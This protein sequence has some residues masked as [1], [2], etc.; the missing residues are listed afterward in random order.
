MEKDQE[1]FTS[2]QLNKIVYTDLDGTITVRDT[3]TKFILRYGNFDTF[4]LSFPIFFLQLFLFS[5]GLIDRNNLKRK[6]IKIFL[7]GKSRELL[8]KLSRD[9]IPSVRVYPEVMQKI[10]EYRQ[11]GYKIIVVTA[12]PSLYVKYFVKYFG[13]DGYI[14]TELEERNGLLTGNVIGDNNNFHVKVE[15]IKSSE[16]FIEGQKIVAFG[17]SK[18]DYGMFDLSDEFFYVNKKGVLLH[19]TKP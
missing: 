11:E 2:D 8:E 5:I 9:F 7:Q 12:S 13:F 15:N 6:T 10:D 16:Y 3:Y 18:G 19:N 14:A 4:L 17:N 1:V